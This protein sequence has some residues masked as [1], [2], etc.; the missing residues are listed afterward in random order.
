MRFQPPFRFPQG[1]SF[2]GLAVAVLAGWSAAAPLMASQPSEIGLEDL[3]ACASDGSEGGAGIPL[4]DIVR[5]LSDRFDTAIVTLAGGYCL[6]LTP[7]DLSRSLQQVSLLPALNEVLPADSLRA[8]QTPSGVIIFLHKGAEEEAGPDGQQ[9]VIMELVVEGRRNQLSAKP[10]AR[11]QSQGIVETLV[12][13]DFSAFAD[14]NPAETLNR[15][16]GVAITREGSEGRQVSIRGMSADATRI[17]LNGM[18]ILATGTSIDA[19]GALNRSRSFDF[20][21]FAVDGLQRA[22]LYKT[23]SADQAEGGIAGTIDLQT[24]RPLDMAGQR[25]F[26][27][28]AGYNTNVAHSA[29]GG[30]GLWAESWADGSQAILVSLMY[31]EHRTQEVGFSTVRWNTGG[32]DLEKVNPDIPE[33]W[34][35]RLNSEGDNALFRSRYNRY[36][37]LSRESERSSMLAA[38]QFE[39][40]DGLSLSLTGITAKHRL[41]IT[42]RHLDSAGLGAGDVSGIVINDLAVDGNDILYGDFSHVDIHS[43]L[44]IEKNHTEFQQLTALLEYRLQPHW[45]IRGAFGYSHSAFGSPV[46]D[47]VWFEANDQDF[48]YDYRNNDRVALNRYGFD[49]NDPDQWQVYRVAARGER[50]DNRFRQ[51]KID[52]V[53]DL[54]SGETTDRVSAG[55]SYRQY[56]HSGETLRSH[57]YDLRGASV[58]GL[59]T[60]TDFAGLGVNGTPA[61]W[62][63]P[64]LAALERLSVGERSPAVDPGSLFEVYETTWAGY[65]EW[66][67]EWNWRASRL[68]F[69]TG[70]RYSA[71]AL[72]SKGLLA[73]DTLTAL[74]E[75]RSGYGNW[76][77]SLNLSSTLGENGLVRFSTAKN[78]TRPAAADLRASIQIDTSEGTITQ[79]N[80]GLK[81]LAAT[82]VDLSFERYASDFESMAA[83]GFFYKKIEDYIVRQSNHFSSENLSEILPGDVFFE[84][85]LKPDDD[86]LAGDYAVTRPVNGDSVYLHGLELSLVQGMNLFPGLLESSSL[87]FNYTYSNADA[88]YW[89]E[90]RKISKPLAG[91]SKSSGNLVFGGAR[92]RWKFQ[93][94]ANYRDRYLV[95]A[96]SADGNDES[97]VNASLYGDLAIHYQMDGNLALKVSALNFTN[98]PLDQYVDTSNRVYSYSKSGRDYFLE[99]VWKN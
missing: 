1:R 55:F 57:F 85:Q 11:Y 88:D 32:W 2:N 86:I 95:E 63:T 4:S 10:L 3:G 90:G 97:G 80:P 54:A 76:L 92:G 98:E 64:S 31:G 41:D 17:Q 47:K 21:V 78:I 59:F 62:L 45:Q 18:E 19:R 72:H 9:Q 73:S 75:S 20:N 58:G 83:L 43:E 33:D 99:V 39:P 69:D 77:P 49:V 51:A 66:A 87:A 28:Q 56:S 53:F 14:R 15:L 30:R 82:S 65:L 27:L 79:G 23:M 70:L 8:R 25:E 42:E 12:P 5:L 44:N 68:R 67:R 52:N 36:D 40:N 60:H 46:H 89:D 13:A 29:P 61:R 91:L 48:S 94:S 34:V 7:T 6:S 71:T 96:P 37:I 74:R 38:W 50:V 93:L 26:S 84:Q 81:P 24:P 35:S 16:P 22:S